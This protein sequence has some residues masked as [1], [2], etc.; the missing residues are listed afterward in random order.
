MIS[1]STS[2]FFD[3]SIQQMGGL[4]AQADKLQS[5][6]GTG[7]RL[8]RS[9][10]DPVAAARLRILDRSQRLSQI[11]QQSSDVAM[12]NLTLTDQSLGS[13]A[14]VIT[15]A[16]ELAIQAA[17]GTLSAEQRNSLGIEVADLRKSLVLIA[18]NRNAEGHSLFGGQAAGPAYQDT[19]SGATYIGT[20]MADAFELGEGQT[21]VP[22][23]TGPEIFEFDA[24]AGPTD[25]FAT[26]GALAAALQSPGDPVSAIHTAMD[27]LDAALEKV[28]TAQTVIGAR[29]NWVQIMDERRTASTE[30][31]TE[32]QAEIGGAD[33]GLTLSRLQEIMTVLEASQTSFVRLSGMSLFNILR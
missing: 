21:V 26:L 5:Q 33:L 9:S 23:L 2:A 24:G 27:G 29:M 19:G 4:R 28:T 7:Q 11:D 14:S 3:R 31:A 16:K 30:L 17:S 10:D 12:T 20:G 25:L 15:R 8:S 6:I 13:I 1:L 32:Q 18:N 22:A